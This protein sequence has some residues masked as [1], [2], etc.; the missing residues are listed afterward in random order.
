MKATSRRE[1]GQKAGKN[2]K[3]P[4]QAKA[5]PLIRHNLNNVPLEGLEP[6]TFSLGRSSS[7]IEL[8][9]QVNQSTER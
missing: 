5:E 7:S 3:I 2:R 6:P 9:R 4:G 8:Q 1:N